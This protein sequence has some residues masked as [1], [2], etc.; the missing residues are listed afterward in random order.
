MTSPSTLWIRNRVLFIS[1]WCN[2]LILVCPRQHNWAEFSVACHQG[3]PAIPY[4]LM[5]LFYL[6]LWKKKKFWSNAVTSSIT[7]LL[8]FVMLF[9]LILISISNHI[10]SE[11]CGWICMHLSFNPHFNAS[12]TCLI[13]ACNSVMFILLK[14]LFFCNYIA[15][16]AIILFYFNTQNWTVAMLFVSYQKTSFSDL[17]IIQFFLPHPQCFSLQYPPPPP[18][19]LF[20]FPSQ[21]PQPFLHNCILFETI[22]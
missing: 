1:I 9:V 10:W 18:L 16:L 20:H 3:N 12:F 14:S 19:C 5:P 2:S 21:C 4:M 15:S 22:Q 13:T 17:V 11:N 6:N 7:C 8:Q